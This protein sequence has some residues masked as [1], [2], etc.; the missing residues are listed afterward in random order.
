MYNTKIKAYLMLPEKF[1]NSPFMRKE[2]HK[3]KKWKLILG[4]IFLLPWRFVLTVF[5][6]L[7]Y[8]AIYTFIP[9]GLNPDLPYPKRRRKA[10]KW[11]CT[12]FAIWFI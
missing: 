10:I 1:K 6:V 8:W 3:I 12:F 4:G 5:L 11:F 2:C 9:W 7:V